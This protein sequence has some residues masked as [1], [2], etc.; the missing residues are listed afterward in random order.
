M[1][2]KICGRTGLTTGLYQ[3]TLSWTLAPGPVSQVTV[4]MV[5]FCLTLYRVSIYISH[6]KNTKAN[7]Y[8]L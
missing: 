1:H 4:Q 6:N 8:T 7:D 3:Q 2:Y 5:L